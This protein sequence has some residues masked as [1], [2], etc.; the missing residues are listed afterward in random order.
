MSDFTKNS[1]D[2]PK[3][4]TRR[5]WLR[6]AA[7]MATSAVLLLSFLTGCNKEGQLP[8]PPGGVGAEPDRS[9]HMKVNYTTTKGA[10]AVGYLAPVGTQAST[11]YY[12]EFLVIS[13]MSNS[14]KFKVYPA[15]E[16]EGWQY[17]GTDDGLWLSLSYDGYLYRSNQS[18]RVAWK[19]DGGKL[20]SSYSRWKDYPAGSDYFPDPF[21]VNGYYAGVNFG[22]SKEFTNVE[23]VS[24]P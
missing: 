11:P 9:Y 7:T 17:L 1:E 14:T 10:T 23:L 19:I 13:E 22:K 24:A 3:K 4:P 12:S 18:N 8:Q 21:V 5:N 16:G 20:Y 6:N 15:T 2:M